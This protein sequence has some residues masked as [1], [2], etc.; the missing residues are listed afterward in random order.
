VYQLSNLALCDKAMANPIREMP[1]STVGRRP[2]AFPVWPPAAG[3]GIVWQ[4]GRRAREWFTFLLDVAL[5]TRLR[6]AQIR[7][8]EIVFQ[9]VLFCNTEYDFFMVSSGAFIYQTC[10]SSSPCASGETFLFLKL[11]SYGTLYLQVFGL[12]FHV[13]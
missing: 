2:T 3:V 11:S 12:V 9:F 5:W 6:Q 7:L 1:E 8:T 13:W 10:F 4:P